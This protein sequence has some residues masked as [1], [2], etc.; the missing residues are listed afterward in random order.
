MQFKLFL[1]PG[2]WYDPKGENGSGSSGLRNGT[3]SVRK[4]KKEE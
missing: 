1:F 3:F 2:I 4:Q